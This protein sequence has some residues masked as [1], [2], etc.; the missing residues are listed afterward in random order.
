[1]I[2]KLRIPLAP[3]RIRAL[4]PEDMF[5]ARIGRAYWQTSFKKIPDNCPHKTDLGAYIE[6]VHE[7]HERGQGLLL[8]GDF[9]TGKTSAGVLILKEAIS[10]GGSALMMPSERISSAVVENTEFDEDETLW[11]RMQSVDVLLL[12]DLRR[13]HVKDFGKSVIESLIRRRY[14]QRLPTIVTTNADVEDLVKKYRAAMEA[15]SEKCPPVEFG[16]FNWRTQD[17]D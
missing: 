11:E 2:V 14:D 16:G 4:D 8:T 13:E 7:H 17:N 10:R 12:D 9:G 3:K 6:N 5:R 1:M 15:L